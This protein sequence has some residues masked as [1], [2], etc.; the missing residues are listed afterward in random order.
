[1]S[2][3][4]NP[5]LAHLFLRVG[6]AF[7]FIYPP[8]AAIFDPYSWIGYFP[9]FVRALPIDQMVL[10]HLFGALEI[11]IAVWLLSGYKIRIPSALAAVILLAIVGFD[12]HSFDVLFR[13][14]SIAAMAVALALLPNERSSLQP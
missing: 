11:G 9:Q 2:L 6:L 5:A 3:S 1:M 12:W 13:D 14:L 8:I 10:L 4:S 7:A